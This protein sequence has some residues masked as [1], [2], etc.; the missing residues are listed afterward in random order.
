MSALTIP[1][2]VKTNHP[3]LTYIMLASV[4][5]AIGFVVYLMCRHE[6]RTRKAKKHGQSPHTGHHGNH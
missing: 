1:M 3:I 4:S 5:V 2:I 6:H